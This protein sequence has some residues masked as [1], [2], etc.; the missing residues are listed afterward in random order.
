MKNDSGSDHASDALFRGVLEA[1]P[2]A[3]IVARPD[4]TILLANAQAERLFGYAKHELIGSAI[5]ILVPE[6]LRVAHVGHRAAFFDNPRMRMMGEGQELRGR[7]KDGTEFPVEIGLSSIET[8]DGLLV[9]SAIRDVSGRAARQRL[10]ALGQLAGG[11]VHE[12]RTPLGVISNTVYYLRKVGEKLDEE[13]RD[14]IADIEREV[15]TAGRIVEELLDYV[16]TPQLRLSSFSIRQAMELALSLVAIPDNV[17]VEREHSEGNVCADS[18]GVQ[19]ILTN[20]IRNAVQAM[21]NGGELRL[22]TVRE[23]G[24][25]ILEVIDTGDGIAEQDIAKVFEPL[26]TTKPRGIGLGLTVAKRYAEMN[27]GRLEVAST[28]GRGRCFAWFCSSVSSVAV[29]GP[30]LSLLVV[31][32]D[33]GTR[34]SLGRILRLDGYAVETMGSAEECL[35]RPRWDDLFAILLD[36]RLGDATADQILPEIRQRAPSLPVVIVTGFADLDSSVAALRVGAS[37]FLVKP[38]NPDALRATLRRMTEMRQLREDFL[39]AQKMEAVGRLAGGIAHDFNNLL[40]ALISGCGMVRRMVAGG[41]QE[42]ALE[43]LDRLHGRAIQ[44]ASL[45]RQLLDFS[46]RASHRLEVV[47]VNEVVKGSEDMVRR[48]LGE[49]IEFVVSAGT[50]D[51]RVVADRSKLEHILMNLAINSR[52]AMPHGGV[53]RLGVSCSELEE[54]ENRRP[55]GTFVEITIA[56]DGVGMDAETRARVFEPYFTTKERGRGTGL[57]L[58]TVFGVVREFGGDIECESELGRGT[59]FRIHLPRHG[60]AHEVGAAVDESE[61]TPAKE[62]LPRGTGTILVVEDERLLRAG[63]RILLTRLGYDVLDAGSPEQALSLLEARADAID[64][65]LSDV[66]MPGMSGPDLA[67]EVRERFPEVPVLF[68][69]G[70]ADRTLIREGRLDSGVRFL[71]KPFEDAELAALVAEM[72]GGGDPGGE[73]NA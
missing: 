35:A 28:P 62:P 54:I 6:H 21:P 3:M 26:Y 69:S 31:D 42:N 70:H 59:T 41:E 15:G 45:T 53:L 67:H 20:L 51:A 10:M 7:R 18:A 11:V 71:A 14:A 5:E 16:R 38:V 46:R 24:F 19:R 43:M 39:H 44:G 63:L 32:D 73:E 37:D 2:D 13:A 50:D 72:L 57:G 8:P 58:S 12:I 25:A 30:P 36:W 23:G 55:K 1:A 4:G 47:D 33:E 49:D 60:A 9:C 34:K 17:S 65:L 66:I 64:L 68:M 22:R 29:T 56:D 52:D 61:T 40:A 48:L 27:N